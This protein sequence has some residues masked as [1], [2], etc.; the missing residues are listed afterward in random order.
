[1]LA[2]QWFAGAALASLCA[3]A[4]AA[5]PLPSYAVVDR[6]A[7]PPGGYDYLSVDSAAGRLFVAR[8]YGVMAVDLPTRKV[9][10]RL[11]A[12]QDVSA[13]LPIPGGDLMLSTAYGA[14]RAVVYDRRTGARVGEV[15][16]GKSPDA[17][18]Y[19]PASGL[20]LVMNAGGGDITLVDPLKPAAVG[21]IV[22]GGKPEAGA[23]DGHGRV[24][25]NVED[26]NE[27]AVVDVAA[28]K[29]VRRIPLAG[30]EEPTGIAYDAVS[31][32]LIS[33]CHNGVARLVDAE[34]GADRGSVAVGPEADGA[35]LDPARR[36]VFI[37]AKDGTLTIFALGPDGRAGPAETL[38]TAPG[39]RTAAL[40][41][42]TG[43]LYLAAAPTPDSFEIVV[44]APQ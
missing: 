34:T 24:Y 30:C 2:L 6:I 1:V 20:V 4:S 43:R 21:R 19:D 35:I 37:P 42:A 11:V 9:T 36:R 5:A 26:R 28:R 44:V 40:D 10:P 17:A 7:G 25:V 39:A 41:P 18:A 3:L 12:A 16:T 13:V 14:D 29:V 38:A 31:G 15:R 32:V 22:V 8:E 23:S 33:A 27:V